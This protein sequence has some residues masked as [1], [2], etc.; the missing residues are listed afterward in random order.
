[1][2]G[3]RWSLLVYGALLLALGG[4]NTTDSGGNGGPPEGPKAVIG[5]DPASGTVSAPAT[6]TFNAE[7]STGD[8]SLYRWSLN[9]AALGTGAAVVSEFTE[10]GAY[11]VALVVTDVRG[12]EHQAEAEYVVL[13]D[14]DD[15]GGPTLL[16]PVITTSHPNGTASVGSTVHFDSA[17][18]TGN[19]AEYQWYLGDLAYGTASEQGWIFNGSQTFMVRLVVRDG[20]GN[21]AEAVMPYTVLPGSFDLEGV[22]HLLRPADVAGYDV[23]IQPSGPWTAASN[24]NWLRVQPTSGSG[25]TTTVRLSVDTAHLNDAENVYQ[26]TL[27]VDD[28]SGRRT[29]RVALLLPQ[30]GAI[31]PFGQIQALVG[32]QG[33]RE[34]GLDNLGW[35][36]LVVDIALTSSEPIPATV[37]APA[38]PI[39]PAT[40]LPLEL[41]VSCPQQPG[42]FESTLVITT[43]DPRTSDLQLPVRIVCLDPGSSQFK[44]ELV[45]QTGSFTTAQ[46]EDIR[47]AARKLQS[48]IVGQIPDNSALPPGIRN[49]CLGIISDAGG[50]IAPELQGIEYVEGLLVYVHKKPFVEN[51]LAQAGPCIWGEGLPN[52]GHVRVNSNQLEFMSDTGTLTDVMVHELGHVLGIG[53]LWRSEHHDLVGPSRQHCANVTL[54][55]HRP[56][57]YT[58]ALGITEFQDLGGSGEPKLD[59]ICAHWSEEAFQNEALTPT[60]HIDWAGGNHYNPV[61]SMTIGALDDLGYTVDYEAADPY[62]LPAGVA[63]LIGPQDIGKPVYR[64]GPPLIGIPGQ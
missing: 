64:H 30:L 17:G 29:D 21:E 11:A 31:N 61:S 23:T 14:A 52:Y 47:A 51:F 63:G 24:A 10:P 45:F 2:S 60:I 9:G 27:T 54:E 19:I 53:T 12:S 33:I 56:R 34:R 50:P 55:P 4:C 44:V 18:S 7:A 25:G 15:G 49:S 35:S 42:S 59:D 46:Q 32:E 28:A 6:V 48:I 36:D 26:A 39:H 43:N 5:F 1:M 16:R 41:G 8:I 57:T 40:Q 13:E 3:W 62:E 58:G 38:D 37:V 22:D 20:D